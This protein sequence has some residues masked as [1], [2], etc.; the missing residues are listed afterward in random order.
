VTGYHEQVGELTAR[1]IGNMDLASM[2]PAARVDLMTALSELATLAPPALGPGVVMPSTAVRHPGCVPDR[3]GA[4]SAGFLEQG[5]SHACNSD[6]GHDS[7]HQCRCGHAWDEVHAQQAAGACGLSHQETGAD[8][9]CVCHLAVHN[10]SQCPDLIERPL[11]AC[12]Q[13]GWSWVA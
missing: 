2:A 4:C 8:H 7:Q 9:T 13:C 5:L 10:L 6:P 3:P 1:I 12:A 11:H